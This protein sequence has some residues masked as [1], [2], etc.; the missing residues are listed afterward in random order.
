MEPRFE[1]AVIVGC[2]LIGGSLALTLREHDCVERLVAV[3]PDPTARDLAVQLGVVD[4]AFADLAEAVEDADLIVFAT[5]VR[6]TCAMLRELAALPLLP[7]C[8]ISDVGSTK[9]QVCAEAQRVLP[10]SVHFIGGHPM[11]GSEKSGVRAASVRLFENAIYVLTPF[12]DTDAEVLGKLSVTLERI[13]AQVLVLTPQIHDRVV[14][15]ISHVPHI[16]A[17]QLV[18]QV[19]QLSSQAEDGALYVQ[20]AAG[21]FRDVTRIASGNPQMWRDIVLSNKAT[22]RDLLSQWKD[23]VEHFL[24]LL[25]QESGEDVELFFQKAAQF[26]DALPA[27]SR[28]AV[29]SVYEISLDVDDRPG[30]I[31]SIATLMGMH[32]INLTSVRLIESREEDNGQL[33]IT[34]SSKADMDAGARVL[35]I[36]GFRVYYRE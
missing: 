15:A 11:A 27:K 16:I 13:K 28:G 34:F 6:Q 32:E 35:L 18:D 20:L 1:K 22:I 24:N 21:G 12:A 19:A 8:I 26:R 5:P 14:A 30:V 29:R 7:G 10:S 25:E 2:G 23:N 36:N 3:D 9:E 33:L 4:I 17:A 31:G